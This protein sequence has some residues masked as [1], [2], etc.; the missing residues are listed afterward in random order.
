MLE[1]SK[2]GDVAVLAFDDG[3]ANVVG[4]DFI[5]AMN[6]GLDR[7]AAEAGAVIVVGRPG[8]FSAGFDLSELQKGAD[9]SAAL[10]GRGAQMLLRMFT[11]P[12]PVVA[13]CTGHAIA[14]GALLLLA[15][16]TRIGVAGDFKIGLNET[17]I[18]M[19]LPV[20]GLELAKARLSKRRLTAAVVQSEIYDPTA[21]MDAGF[22]DEVVDSADLLDAAKARAAV[23][24]GYPSG[25]YANNKLAVR[26][27]VASTI[28]ASLT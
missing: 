11:H 23:L 20:F 15:C 27:E 1:F 3:K 5:D 2:D 21:A 24:A 22:L 18:G 26:S 6:E 16:D 17:A 8:R 4:H 12:Q 25:A 13:A 28:R 9:A 14:A 7:A 19:A 10:V